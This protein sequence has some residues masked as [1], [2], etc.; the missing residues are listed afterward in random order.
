[1]LLKTLD[2]LREKTP[3]LITYFLLIII[4]ALVSNFVLPLIS[5]LDE[6][7][8]FG[9]ITL[10]QAINIFFI[11]AIFFLIFEIW[12]Q[13]SPVLNFFVERFYSMLPGSKKVEKSSIRRI[14]YDVAYIIIVILIV[15]SV[16]IPLSY[17]IQGIN[18]VFNF[19][20][21]IVIFLLLFD[22]GRTTYEILSS[23]IEKLNGKFSSTKKEK[24]R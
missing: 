18:N 17:M 5:F 8:I 24:K 1:M 11:A 21:L 10:Y 7:M 14:L 9:N 3:R 16:P 19:I 22:L 20:G 23:K 13:L 15:T 12:V 4:F 6:T 2:Q